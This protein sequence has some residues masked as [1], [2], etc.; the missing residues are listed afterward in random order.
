MAVAIHGRLQYSEY[1]KLESSLSLLVAF[2]KKGVKALE[3]L[4]VKLLSLAPIVALPIQTSRESE[5]LTTIY[6]GY[7]H[8]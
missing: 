2:W 5:V 4:M 7:H 6:A 8:T 3:P 1:Q